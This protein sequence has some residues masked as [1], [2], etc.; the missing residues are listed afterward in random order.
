MKLSDIEFRAMNTGLR[1][2]GQKHFELPIFQRL[3]LDPRGRDLLEVGCGNGH[4][5]SLLNGLQPKSYLGF[6]LMEEQLALA[7]QRHPQLDFRL[8]DATDLSSIPAASFDDAVIFGVLHHIPKWR[9]ALDELARVLRPNGH[10]FL[11][12]P[13][14]TDLRLFDFFFRWAHP[15][16]D[17]SLRGL[18]DHL[19]ARGWTRVRK[20]WTP[21]MTMYCWGR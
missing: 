15:A 8:L 16:S 6:D 3:G 19:R 18:E 20:Q 14:G 11:E 12:E 1:R 9:A 5:A 4:G 2:A 7:R 10:L 13:R 17:F 21:L